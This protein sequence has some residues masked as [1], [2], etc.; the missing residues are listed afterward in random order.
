M[1]YGNDSVVPSAS[2]WNRCCLCACSWATILV[3]ALPQMLPACP[4]AGLW[5]VGAA[6]TRE[7]RKDHSWPPRAAPAQPDNSCTPPHLLRQDLR[8]PRGSA[9]PRAPDRQL[10]LAGRQRAAG[11]PT[12]PSARPP[13]RTSPAKSGLAGDLRGDL[14]DRGLLRDHVALVREPGLL[15]PEVHRGGVQG[16]GLHLL[17]PLYVSAEF[18]NNETGEIKGQTVFMGDFPLMTRQGHLHHQR[19]R[20]RRR[21]PARPLARASTSS[22]PPTRPPTRTSS[23]PR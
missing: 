11:R 9:A 20:A 19:H 23:P 12:S 13:A 14:P 2:G 6:H 17:R 5:W 18:T 1:L 15:R 4:V 7:P 3:C 16:E 10:R 8:T 22:A 21:L